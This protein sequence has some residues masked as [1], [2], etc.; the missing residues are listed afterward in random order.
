VTTVWD[1]EGESANGEA[2]YTVEGDLEPVLGVV[3]CEK[4]GRK[5]VVISSAAARNQADKQEILDEV[6]I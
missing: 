1:V 3:T 5:E 2:D 6:Y 4:T